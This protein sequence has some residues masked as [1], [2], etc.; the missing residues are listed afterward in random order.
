[1]SRQ[2]AA[3]RIT[4]AVEK[5]EVEPGDRIL[6]V[7]CGHGVAVSEVCERLGGG[8]IVAIDRSPKMIEAALKRNAEQVA[9]GKASFQAVSL[10]EAELG[11]GKFDKVFAIHVAAFVRG[12]P[13]RELGIVRDLLADGG[14]LYLFNQPLQAQRARELAES[15]AGVLEAH[16]FTINAVIVEE[17]TGATAFCVVARG[18]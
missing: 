8:T 13:E 4:W 12:Q 9:A 2:A 17:L 3:E 6:E 5:L 16:G 10:H 7:G 1:V 18:E 14:R 15:E 11:E